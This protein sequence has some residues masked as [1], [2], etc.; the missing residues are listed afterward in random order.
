MKTL[1]NLLLS[2]F[3]IASI[4]S[5]AQNEFKMMTGSVNIG[6]G[7]TYY[8]YDSGGDEEFTVAEDPENNFRWKTW[9]QHNESYVLNLVIPQGSTKGIKVTFRSLLINNDHLKIYEGDVVDETKLIVDLT[10]NDYSTGYGSFSVMS[11]GNMT[12][13]FKS[14]G[15]YRDAGW[16]A[17]VKLETFAPQAPIIMRK[18]CDNECI[19]LSTCKG[20]NSTSFKYNVSES[21]TPADPTT[22]TAYTLGNSIDLSNKNYPVSVSA[23]AYIDNVAIQAVAKT[24]TSDI[25]APP[26]TT[27]NYTY[28]A[29]KNTID[30]KTLRDN[31]INDTW[32]VRYIMNKTAVQTATDAASWPA[33]EVWSNAAGKYVVNDPN[34]YKE[35]V[36]PGGTIDYTNTSMTPDFYVHMLIR[37]TTC[38]DKFS[39]I[40]T[41]KVEHIYIPKPEIV[42]ETTG[43]TIKTSLAGAT[44]YYTINGTNPDMSSS[45]KQVQAHYY[46][47]KGS[48]EQK[49]DYYY[50]T[51]DHVTAGTTVKA[52]AIKT[53]YQNSEIASAIYS[54]GSGIVPGTGI[55]LL[56]DREDHSWSYYS[57]GTQP[58]HSLKPADIKI[59]YF[60]NGT[61]TVTSDSENGVAPTTFSLDATDVAVSGYES[62]NQFV[63]LKTL[64]N[65]NPE[66]SSGDNQSYP[67]TLIPNPFSKRPTVGTISTTA[68][69]TCWRGFYGWRV[70]E[71]SGVT[72]TGYSKGDIIP[73][74]TEI[75]F[76]TSNTEGNEVEF[77]AM[78]AQAWFATAVNNTNNLN[79]NVSYERNFIRIAANINQTNSRP[80]TIMELYPNGTTNGTTAA[81]AAPNTARNLTGYSLS[82]DTKFEYIALNRNSGTMTANNHYLCFGRGINSSRNAAYVQ[83]ISGN[84]SANLNY[85]LRVESGQYAQFAIVRNGSGNVSGTTRLKAIFGN[86]YD[87]AN[88][89]NDLLD[90]SRESSL[91]YACQVHFQNSGDQNA[92]VLN[93]IIK[94]GQYQSDYWNNGGN[95]LY[96]H[97]FYLGQ[98]QSG[99]DTYPGLRKVLVEG[100]EFGSMNGGRGTTP[101]DHAPSNYGLTFSL[102]IKDGTFNGSVF[103]GA[104]DNPSP[105][106]REIIITGGTI[107]GWVAGGCN[108]TGDNGMVGNTVGD[109]KIYIGGNAV[110]GGDSPIT[111]N[112]TNGGQ[113][114]GAGR[115][116]LKNNQTQVASIINSYVVIA[117]NS[118]IK[119]NVYGGGNYG[120]IEETSNVYILGGLVENNVFGGA[121][122]NDPI[123]TG[124]NTYTK[125]IP[126]SNV[127]MKGGTINGSVYGGSNSSGIVQTVKMNITGGTIKGS[128]FGGGLGESTKITGTVKLTIGEKDAENGPNI[129]GIENQDGTLNGGDVY[130]GS[131]L[132]IVNAANETAN[133]RN[134]DNTKTIEVIVNNGTIHGNVYGGGLGNATYAANVGKVTVDINDG[135]MNKVFGCNNL[136]GAPQ[137]DVIVN[138]NGGEAVDVYG[139]GNLADYTATGKYPVVNVTGGVVSNNVYGGGALAKVNKTKVN[140]TGGDVNNVFAGAQG[141]NEEYAKQK[142]NYILVSGNKTLNM[143]GGTAMAVY[144]GSFTCQDVA[145]SFVNISGGHIKTHVFGSGYFGD[146]SGDCFIYI[147]ENAITSAP[148]HTDNTDRL[149]ADTDIEL[150][151]D[152]NI[153]IESNVYAG[154]NWGS[155]DGTFGASTIEGKSNIYIDGTDY[156]MDHGKN[157]NYMIIGGSVYGS[158]TSCEAG[159]TDHSVIVRNY[160]IMTYPSMTRSLKS[161]QRVK[162]LVL[163]NSSID[164]VGQGD[165]S[166]MDVTV[167]YGMCNVETVIATNANNM[168][169][170]KP[171]DKIH[172]LGS[173]TCSNVYTATYPN[174]YTIVDIAKIY[175]NANLQ[176]KNGI[177]INNGGYLM[178]R[179]EN[180]SNDKI[181]GE[182]AGYF[183]MREPG[184]DKGINNEGY[185]FARPKYILGNGEYWWNDETYGK[186]SPANVFATDGGFVDFDKNPAK[187]CYDAN[188]NYIA[189]TPDPETYR[190]DATLGNPVQMA[191]TNRTEKPTGTRDDNPA[192]GDNGTDYRFWRY[193]PETFPVVTREVVFVVKADEQA[194]STST[195]FLTTKDAVQLPPALG[196]N[197]KYYITSLTWGADGKDCNPAPYAATAPKANNNPEVGS[198]WIYYDAIGVGET[199]PGFKTTTTPTY[200]EY[201]ANPNATFGFL[202]NFSGSLKSQN[203][204]ILDNE[205]YASY[206]N[207]NPLAEI[208]ATNTTEL[209]QLDFLVTYSDRLSQN[210]LWSEARVIID[211]VEEK[212][213]DNKI[214][215]TTK[216][217][218]Y[219]NISVT[220]STKFGSNVE[221]YVYASTDISKADKTTGLAT[222]TA[223]LTLPMFTLANINLFESEFRVQEDKVLE[224]EST[225]Y[226]T[227]KSDDFGKVND[228]Q[229][230]DIVKFGTVG[231]SSNL[232]LQFY[233]NKNGDNTQGWNNMGNET[234]PNQINPQD[235]TTAQ[236]EL[237]GVADGRK[238]TTISFDLQYNPSELAKNSAFGIGQ[239][240]L[241]DLIIHMTADNVTDNEFDI[242]VHVYVSGPTKYYYLDGVAGKDGNS[243]MFPDDAK[244]TLNGVINASGFSINDP[245]FVVNGVAPK[246]NG[247]LTWNADKFLNAVKVEE[248]D[249]KNYTEEQLRQLSQVKV[250]RYPGNHPKKDGETDNTLDQDNNVVFDNGMYNGPIINVPENS[251][252]SMHNVWISGS[253]E[254]NDATNENYALYNPE[255]N[256]IESNVPL[257]SI[258]SGATA[259]IENSA[260]VNNNNT[261]STLAGA[262]YNE[263]TLTVNGIYIKGNVSTRKGTGVYQAGEMNLGNTQMIT[264]ADQIYLDDR[265]IMNAP[266]GKLFDGS[267]F[268]DILVYYNPA[269]IDT[270]YSGRVIVRYTGYEP[271]A[272][273][274]PYWKNNLPERQS[275]ILKS[276][277]D[278]TDESYE[279]DKYTLN[280]E[281]SGFKKANGGDENVIPFIT[282][283]MKD[284]FG[285]TEYDIIMYT[286]QANLPV[287]LLYFT[288]ECMGEAT[289]LQWST[290]SETN[291]EYFTIERSSDAV[292]Y[293]EIARIQG[294]G[295]TSQRNDYS[296][297]VDNN[298]NA[299][300]YYRL[301]QTDI[302][303]KY[304]IFAPIA[305]QCQNNKA[306]TE[307]SIYPVP[308]ND[309]VNIFSS[310][311]PMTRVEIYSI[312]G[313]K[314]SEEQVE[315]HQATLQIGHLATGVY[316]AKI[317]TEDGQVINVRL[318]KK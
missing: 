274:A 158:G 140:M 287:E 224:D 115:G 253:N 175:D 171:M 241:G 157:G 16:I 146:M 54:T 97:S 43:D 307:I 47:E 136:N 242:I 196:D 177:V 35:I 36:N 209:P 45:N 9:Y 91:F 84:T 225:K 212:T 82:A 311:S 250:Y 33:Y 63:Y 295:T 315:G 127:T 59:T 149:T 313:N 98:N 291:N 77:E 318:I 124:G 184:D 258:A 172:K 200:D 141:D 17:E 255:E 266:N 11:H 70:K 279:S 37:G 18:A 106:S 101:T 148:N 239:K 251:T 271:S 163:D 195:K 187:N 282:Y 152:N 10:N 87:R 68:G 137:G 135:K 15:Q 114:F 180:Q 4:G 14:D 147:G 38:P 235:F 228:V 52:M 51:I 273:P 86:D 278:A 168:A 19:V 21:N 167:E 236:G 220:T 95:G 62:A 113:V 46:T 83:G 185:I 122:G 183:F 306:A 246:T 66:G 88:G 90:V 182:L 61:G 299:I 139:G 99:S 131:A 110:I 50:I 7:K 165:I 26:F 277:K 129:V 40:K 207:E 233:A 229:V 263:G 166:S 155:F 57:D 289:Q 202:M 272:E 6:D 308:A 238:Y 173:Y 151:H 231:T 262:I 96:D 252:F 55:V 126:T 317:H 138:F 49:I 60:G 22:G 74:E 296:F 1:K 150:N 67:Y 93:C 314:V 125:V 249:L 119:S 215:R 283:K 13:Q 42:F 174:D 160:G 302:D 218:I 290:A 73:A 29:A 28:T 64:E 221:T 25:S 120:Y 240:Y 123:T 48:N 226:G 237:I 80:A 247:S 145:K 186:T 188:G 269:P 201:Y 143:Q 117:D 276:R 20:E 69:A 31:N 153:W 214:V 312:M 189:P 197:H 23:V 179:Y 261:N 79:E 294:A 130:G 265:K 275:S 133:N 310:N 53:N 208:D 304:E 305:I 75:E 267:S 190:K 216:Q 142:E 206:F 104:A 211:E 234:Y 288:A 264:I 111:V 56:D 134:V 181:Y 205:S 259:T 203:A 164:F 3:V 219:L 109:A 116:C 71:L 65:A 297:M 94:S 178:V 58:V 107:Y 245:I 268:G 232:A 128:V 254:L 89:K 81:T 44:I 199:D 300:T 204:M 213:V 112:T 8:F 193:E 154:A 293:E 12:L 156:N 256:T 198:N 32:Y 286:N 191:Y 303:G 285:P 108:G 284:E 100:G 41:V 105:G 76:V 223:S 176:A 27:D 280:K 192:E 169:L 159:A 102:R 121:Y 222:Y 281:L 227:E 2:L 243:G 85:T 210:E 161:I 162:Q 132:G 72:I 298:S 194:S 5:M 78:W 92:E 270:S 316:A 292:N 30:V 309:Q 244:R 118:K 34:G 170:S 301:R 144:G 39:E 257:I 103:G 230:V 217:R 260:L 248:E 24:F